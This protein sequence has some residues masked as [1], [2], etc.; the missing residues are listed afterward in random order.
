MWSIIFRSA[1]RKNV[2]LIFL[3]N[4]NYLV[5][6]IIYFLKRHKKLFCFIAIHRD[7][8]YWFCV[9]SSSSTRDS[10]S[11]DY[12]YA[13]HQKVLINQSIIYHCAANLQ[14]TALPNWLKVSVFLGY[15]PRGSL[16]INMSHVRPVHSL[17]YLSFWLSD[18]L[19]HSHPFI[20]WIK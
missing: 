16:P 18:R 15:F 14:T 11:P 6:Y 12:L 13:S 8:A 10:G 1:I 2:H 17:F 3:N 7:V 20:S 19:S 4:H 9:I 5:C